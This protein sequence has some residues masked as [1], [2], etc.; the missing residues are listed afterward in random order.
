MGVLVP[1][2]QPVVL[3]GSS[4]SLLKDCPQSVLAYASKDYI[5]GPGANKVSGWRGQSFE[6]RMQE[7]C[8][9]DEDFPVLCTIGNL[10]RFQSRL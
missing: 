9:S 7:L 1:S 6:R 8:R 2:T 10:P 3:Y 4:V 5:Q